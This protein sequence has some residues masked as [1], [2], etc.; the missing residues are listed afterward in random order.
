MAGIGS[1]EGTG[2]YSTVHAQK[3]ANAFL[4]AQSVSAGPIDK[5]SPNKFVWM[6]PLALGAAKVAGA[7]LAKTA[8]G[9]AVAKTVAGVG[10]KLAATKVGGA[11]V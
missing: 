2:D 3:R 9:A 8:V 10:A 4:M 5:R 1:Y 7:A 6:I 11:V